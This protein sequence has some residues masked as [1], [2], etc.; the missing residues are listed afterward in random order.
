MQ[1]QS[2]AP[3]SRVHISLQPTGPHRSESLASRV[4]LLASPRSQE[5][6]EP[7]TGKKCTNDHTG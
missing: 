3:E 1:I 6:S 7:K 4:F 5:H 2:Y